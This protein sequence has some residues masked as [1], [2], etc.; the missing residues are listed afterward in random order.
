MKRIFGVASAG[1]ITAVRVTGRVA[2]I[3]S[4]GG[5]ISTAVSGSKA[6]D[7]IGADVRQVRVG[8]RARLVVQVEGQ[9]GFDPGVD[10]GRGGREVEIEQRTD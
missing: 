6:P 3:G 4:E 1:W 7:F 5:R 2:V 10:G 9:A 8:I